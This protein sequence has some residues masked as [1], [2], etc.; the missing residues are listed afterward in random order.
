M[1]IFASIVMLEIALHLSYA[2]HPEC[3]CLIL[4]TGEY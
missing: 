3:F 2:W 1:G 4:N